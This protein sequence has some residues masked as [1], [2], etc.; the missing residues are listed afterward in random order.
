MLSLE[1]HKILLKL[2]RENEELKQKLMQV[3]RYVCMKVR[4]VFKT[5]IA[6]L[7]CNFFITENLMKCKVKEENIQVFG[8]DCGFRIIN[9]IIVINFIIIVV[10]IYFPLF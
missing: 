1:G 3:R 6:V 10:D 4:L 2:T 5:K 9:F 8:H 7:K